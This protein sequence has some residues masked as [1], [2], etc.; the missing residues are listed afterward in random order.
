MLSIHDG[1]GEQDGWLPLLPFGDGRLPSRCG[2][3][4][5]RPLGVVVLGVHCLQCEGEYQPQ[6]ES[7]AAQV[8][9][10]LGELLLP[11]QMCGQPPEMTT[12]MRTIV[13][14]EIAQEKEIIRRRYPRRVFMNPPPPPGSMRRIDEITDMWK[15]LLTSVAQ[16]RPAE[17]Q[18]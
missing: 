5:P 1:G 15:D 16:D 6:G 13:E 7:A 8:Q 14:G 2:G 10:V 12:E 11:A 3:N 17:A 9:V 18:P 4:L